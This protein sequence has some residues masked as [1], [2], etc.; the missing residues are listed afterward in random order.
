[1]SPLPSSLNYDQFQFVFALESS[2][3]MNPLGAHQVTKIMETKPILVE[4]KFVWEILNFP[5]I[6]EPLIES[7]KVGIPDVDAEYWVTILP[8]V[9][10]GTD[11]NERNKTLF[12]FILR[13]KSEAFK[14]GKYEYE[15]LCMTPDRNFPTNISNRKKVFQFPFMPI[16]NETMTNSEYIRTNAVTAACSRTNSYILDLKVTVKFLGS[17]V[18]R[19]RSYDPY[20]AN[21]SILTNVRQMY[22]DP[23]FADFTFL[24]MEKEFKVHKNILAAA[25][26]VFLKMFTTKMEESRTNQ[27]RVEHIKPE[28]FEK[29]LECIYKGKLPDDFGDF[30]MD[31]YSAADYYGIDRL[32]ELCQSEVHERLSVVNAIDTYKWACRYDLDE[33]KRDAWE[34]VKRLDQK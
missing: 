24:V 20:A 26:P 15:V 5:D 11:A 1:M 29:L 30:A 16:D 2:F 13:M 34:I 12:N 8:K 21:N 25:S 28:I 32:K 27:C 14:Q 23:T 6:N 19:T 3:K 7:S 10:E 22:N 31:L 4:S 9:I 17:S 33:L 18:I